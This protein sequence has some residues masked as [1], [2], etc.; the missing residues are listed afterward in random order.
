MLDSRGRRILLAVLA[1]GF[2]LLT[3]VFNLLEWQ[4]ETPRSVPVAILYEVMVVAGFT[5]LWFLLSTIFRHRQASPL[6]IFW[7]T[8][9]VGIAILVIT[10]LVLSIG[11]ASDM[12]ATEAVLGFEYGTGVPLTLVTV[13]KMNVAG[14]LL[15]AF[16]FYLLLRFRDLVLFKRT[17]RSQR[18]WYLMLGLMGLG[19]LSAVLKDPMSDPTLL[20]GVAVVPAVILMSINAFRVSWIVFLSFREKVAGIGLSVLLIVLLSLSLWPGDLIPGLESFLKHYSYPLQLF[21]MMALG[22]GL[23]YCVT[24]FLFLVFHL[25]TT[26]D[27]QRKAGE[28]TAMHSLT[29]L[30][31][32]VFDSDRLYSTIT[33]TPVEA[34]TADRAWLALADARSG[35]LRPRIV[36]TFKTEIERVEQSIDIQSFYE[37]VDAKREPIILDEAA[38]DHRVNMR[39]GGPLGSLLVTPLLARNEM[40]GALFVGKDV[41][42]GFEKDDVE[43]IS[44]YA[45]QAAIALENA[46]LFEE[47]LEKE[48]L[49]RELD[50]ARAVQRKLLP[51]TLPQVRGLTIAA[52]S[53]SA[54]EVG[55]DYYDFLRLD[56]ERLAF[57]V[58]DVS[59][60]GTSAAFYMAELQGIFRSV[61]RL[62]STPTDFL[63][64]ANFALASALERNAFVSV[65]Y[66]IIDAKREE[67]RIVRGG[68]CP[69]AMISLDG[70]ARFIRTKG[71]GL[72]LDRS[73]LFRRSLVEERISLHPGD[74]FVLYTDGVVESRNREGHEYG[75]ERLLDALKAYRHEDAPELHHSLLGD[76]NGFLEDTEYDDDLTLVVLKWHGLSLAELTNTEERI[77]SAQSTVA[78]AVEERIESD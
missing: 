30:V 25:P 3:A 41:T 60:K 58:A 22:F 27:F 32:Q 10:R 50:I 47:Q 65:I 75:Y 69:A 62:T 68:H 49:S 44:V 15:T 78:E 48:R 19:S 71:L 77:A 57:I 74:V 4:S 40:L 23:L 2:F 38:A 11:L 61:S 52:S 59:G 46:Q 54:H 34:G 14:L 29:N 45:A 39:P 63:E 35:T 67:L 1:G 31:G 73:D 53:V 76:L 55:G 33:A 5:S 18:N 16:A 9:L 17:R 37:E 42:Q 64:Q 28:V 21:T 51:Q 70:T 24:S 43:A 12:G 6:K 13:V 72:G 56:E 20:Q 7:T 26:S 66:G 8:L 36:A